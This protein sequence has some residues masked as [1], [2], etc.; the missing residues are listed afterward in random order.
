M[1]KITPFLWFDN[2]AEEAAHFYTSIF[3]NSKIGNV[4]RY[5]EGSPGPVGQV[6]VIEFE[7]D[8]QNFRALNGGPL[9]T[10]SPAISFSI[11]CEDQ[12][13]VDHYWDRLVEGG[14]TSQ[15]GWLDDKFGLSWQVVPNVLGALLSDPDPEKA[16]RVMEAMLKMVK[17]DIAELDRAHRGEEIT[18]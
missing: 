17:L 15:C 4:S 8:G 10:F 1:E 12:A 14:R 18:V 11:G 9:F 7:L 13:E 6:M 2:Q 3:K 5:T 16:Q